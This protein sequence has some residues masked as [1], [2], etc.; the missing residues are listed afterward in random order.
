MLLPNFATGVILWRTSEYPAG[1]GCAREWPEAMSFQPGTAFIYAV[2][3][4]KSRE[5]D[6]ERKGREG[7]GADWRAGNGR[8]I[9]RKKQFRAG[10][11]QSGEEMK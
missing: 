2:A 3:C 5:T 11:S 4:R 6:P 8:V 9:P 7:S 1:E 10:G